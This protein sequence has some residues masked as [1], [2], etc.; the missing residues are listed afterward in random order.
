MKDARQDHA[1]VRAELVERLADA[2]AK[3]Q[4]NT[5]LG[6]QISQLVAE[7]EIDGVDHTERLAK[8]R[9]EQAEIVQF[10]GT[11]P[12]V[13]AELERRLEAAVSALQQ[14][15]HQERL[16]EL[17]TL[18]SMEAGQRDAFAGKAI[19]LIEV[20]AALKQTLERKV[21]IRGEILESGRGGVDIGNPELP[22]FHN[23]WLQSP[24]GMH[25]ARQTLARIAA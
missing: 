5:E 8:L 3:Q 1:N 4:R 12:D 10:L 2:A 22:P 14:Q 25:E 16:A 9:N 21:A 7:Q 11:W 18:R 6:R 24:Q 19:E 17:D 20:S 13:Q 23:G 15:E